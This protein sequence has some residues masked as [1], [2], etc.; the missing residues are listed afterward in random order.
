[1]IAYVGR[2]ESV[3]GPDFLLRAVEPLFASRPELRTLFVGAARPGALPSLPGVSHLGFRTDVY[4]VLR[5][6]DIFCL[7]SV[8]EGLPNALMEAM[9]VGCACVATRVGGVPAL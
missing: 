2:L 9:A 7:P 8:Y 5:R 1:W 3:K 6:V 4:P